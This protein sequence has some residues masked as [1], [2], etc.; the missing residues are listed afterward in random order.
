MRKP[1]PDGI[2]TA[3]IGGWQPA[4][5]DAH[6]EVPNISSTDQGRLGGA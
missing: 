4:I 3:A 5:V 1:H 2:C 6:L